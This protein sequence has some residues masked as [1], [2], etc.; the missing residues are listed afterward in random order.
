MSH[1]IKRKYNA[2]IWGSLED[3]VG[4]IESRLGRDKKDR[5]KIA[6]L[7]ENE[8]GGKKAITEYEVINE[9][10]FLSLVELTLKTGRTH[11]I[12]VHL[13]SKGHPVFG[14]DSYGGRIP[15]SVKI[16]SNKRARIKNLLDSMP[17]QALHAKIL[18]FFHPHTKKS[19]EF[20]T[21][22][23]EDIRNVIEKIKT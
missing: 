19:L 6:V 7:K 17:R 21:E 4:I 20:S 14:D 3:K 9:Y 5:K 23:P 15:H 2:L 10:E 16:T 13:S 12:R 1:S 22:L 11:Q 8:E 18:G